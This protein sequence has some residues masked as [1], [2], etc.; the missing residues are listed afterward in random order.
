MYKVESLISNPRGLWKYYQFIKK[1]ILIMLLSA[2][3]GSIYA[4]T[5]R[6]NSDT[7]QAHGLANSDIWLKCEFTYFYFE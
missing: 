2:D 7:S 3:T 5:G 1:I 4:A 6:S